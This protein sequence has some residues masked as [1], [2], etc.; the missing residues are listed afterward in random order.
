MVYVH[1]T[2]VLSIQQPDEPCVFSYTEPEGISNMIALSRVVG[3]CGKRCIVCG[4]EENR[5]TH[6]LCGRPRAEHRNIKDHIFDKQALRDSH[7]YSDKM[8]QRV[9]GNKN[10][11]VVWDATKGPKVAIRKPSTCCWSLLCKHCEKSTSVIEGNICKRH[12]DKFYE[13]QREGIIHPE[14]FWVFCIF[15]YRAMPVNTNISHFLDLYA[16]DSERKA[17]REV[18]RS[19]HQA[20]TTL[21]TPQSSDIIE[22]SEKGMLYLYHHFTDEHKIEFPFLCK[23][24]LTAIGLGHEWLVYGQM[25]PY[26]W[27]FPLNSDKADLLQ[28]R[29]RQIIQCINSQLKLELGQYYDKCSEA[30]QRRSTTKLVVGYLRKLNKC[31]LSVKM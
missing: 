26:Y 23:V 24:D 31:Y 17:T 5:C 1:E 22:S 4:K 13:S 10:E 14:D 18:I 28:P 11:E 15:T 8:L 21:D 12:D 20:F 27:A 3:T 7:A 29:F 16:S 6:T 30:K 19:L 9:C 25:P 2:F